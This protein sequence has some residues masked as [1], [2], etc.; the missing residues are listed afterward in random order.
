M[1]TSKCVYVHF[2]LL[3]E[4][5]LTAHLELAKICAQSH[6]LQVALDHLHKVATILLFH[7]P[8]LFQAQVL[9]T[10]EKYVEQIKHFTQRL[11]LRAQI[12]VE[13]DTI[14]EKALKVI[15]QVRIMC[16]VMIMKFIRSS[17]HC[18]VRSL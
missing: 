5:R 3:Y 15:E 13:P 12:Y 18:S 1:N 4:V 2:S 14:I 16:V 10:G 8:C 11:T 7:A 17:S 6:Q 9:D